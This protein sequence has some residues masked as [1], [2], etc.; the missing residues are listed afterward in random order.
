MNCIG[1]LPQKTMEIEKL[2]L[3]VCARNS[4]IIKLN[5]SLL[6][7]IHGLTCTCA[8]PFLIEALRATIRDKGSVTGLSKN[9]PMHGHVCDPIMLLRK[10]CIQDMLCKTK[11]S[12]TLIPWAFIGEVKTL[13]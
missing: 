4:I 3:R 10:K 12:W 11:G 1:H 13:I 9:V 8:P 2:S 6:L 5:T 7:T